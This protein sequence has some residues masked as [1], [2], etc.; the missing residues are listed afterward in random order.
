M[1]H[2]TKFKALVTAIASATLCFTAA[3]TVT[4]PDGGEKHVHSYGEWQITTP[5]TCTQD[6]KK[7]RR[8]SAGDDTQVETIP[9]TGH[10][11]DVWIK[12]ESRHYKICDTCDESFSEG[13]HD[14]S[15]SICIVC[16][17]KKVQ[18]ATLSFELNA[19]QSGYIVTGGEGEAVKIPATYQGLPVTEIAAEAFN[20]SGII[21]VEIPGSVKVI[22]DYAFARCSNLKKIEF[23]AGVEEFGAF[24][25]W[26]SGIEEAVIHCNTGKGVFRECENLKS[27]TI[28]DKVTSLP[29]QAFYKCPALQEVEIPQGITSCGSYAFRES[30]LVRVT[31]SGDPLNGAVL[32]TKFIFYGCPDLVEARFTATAARLSYYAFDSCSSLERYVL[33]DDYPYFKS[34]NGIIYSNDL[35]TCVKAGHG[36]N[37]AVEIPE[38]VTTL[39]GEQPFRACTRLTSVKLPSTL[40][41]INNSCFYG[42]G[43]T[44]VNIPDGVSKLGAAVFSGCEKLE[45]VYIGAGV[46]SID[47]KAFTDCLN[48]ENVTVSAQNTVYKSIDNCIVSGY[49]KTHC[50]LVYSNKNNVIPQGVTRLGEYVFSGRDLTSIT[51]PEGIIS[52]DRGAFDGC[53]NLKTVSLPSTLLAINSYAFKNCTSLQSITVPRSVTS[54]SC[55]AFQGCSALTS[56][57]FEKTAGWKVKKNS[58]T[59]AAVSVTVTSSAQNATYLKDTYYNYNWTSPAA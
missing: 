50:Y 39:S 10:S 2:T 34:V 26:T 5:P 31:I 8:C 28:G 18:P 17:Y 4:E 41:T 38:G 11:S 56:A 27:V 58:S 22:G 51:I 16:G 19:D 15:N 59:E 24:V 47:R 7:E 52:I 21:S 48:L 33:D 13:L 35:K 9:K 57:V 1:K 44:S 55:W 6:G 37:G 12:E 45:S 3:C 23:P 54:I 43:L 32:D 30:G 46:T 40:T 20:N 49:G 42:S 25:C 14:F 29:E 53:E 36:I